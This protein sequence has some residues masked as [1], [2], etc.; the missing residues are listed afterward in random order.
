MLEIRQQ[1]LDC[2]CIQHPLKKVDAV[3][4]LALALNSGLCKVEANADLSSRNLNPSLIPGRP[5]KPTLVSPKNVK[6]RAM[7]T[8]EGRAALI[9]ALAHIEFNAINL[10][11]DA[12]WRFSNMPEQYYKDWL[13]VAA[14]EAYHFSLLNQ[15]LIDKGFSYGAFDAHDSLWE[16]ATR[17]SEDVLARIALVPRTMEA[18]GLDASPA[19]RAKFA[20]VGE[21][22]VANTLDIIL[23]D[24][25][26]HVAIGNS[27]FN[28]LCESRDLEPISTYQALAKQY[29]A[30]TPRKPFNHSAR[31][32]A[33]FTEAELAWLENQP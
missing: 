9:H 31:R 28:F 3:H 26:G 19:L 21:T 5:E 4:A 24:E 23:R 12:I 20:Q 10:A 22:E 13:K 27:W 30:P 18:R 7:N 8:T 15:H 32:S 2:L 11:L 6:R 1:S 16:M 29:E 33:G 25:I 14:E 17:T